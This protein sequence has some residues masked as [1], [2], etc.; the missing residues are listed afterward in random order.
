MRRSDAGFAGLIRGKVSENGILRGRDAAWRATTGRVMPP[1]PT[2]MIRGH[3][4]PIILDYNT[5]LGLESATV[6][7]HSRSNWPADAAGRGS[8]GDCRMN[9]LLT[10]RCN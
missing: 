5:A 10:H 4:L 1:Y 7:L 9:N 2:A 3:S 8:N 6:V